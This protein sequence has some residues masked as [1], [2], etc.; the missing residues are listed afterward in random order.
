MKTLT[1]SGIVPRNYPGGVT[2]TDAT[3]APSATPDGRVRPRRVGRRHRLRRVDP[4]LA[5]PR[6]RRHRRG[7]PPAPPDRRRRL[8]RGPAGTISGPLVLV[9]H[10]YG[11][12]VISNAATGH[13]Q[14][15]ALV[16][17]AGWLPDEGERIQQL[18]ESEVSG[19]VWC[20]R[21]CDRCRSPTRMGAR[22]WT[23]SWIA[24]CSPRRLPPTST[25]RRPR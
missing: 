14:V 19:T 17:T 11:G 7:Q 15:Q 3:S 6:V 24:S 20:R 18:L 2:M 1:V 13:Q 12:A 9:G 23:C 16:F 4:C 22:G 21:R 10:S 5:R 8:P 25:P